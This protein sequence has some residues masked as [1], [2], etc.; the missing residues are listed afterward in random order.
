MNH[1]KTSPTT[2]KITRRLDRKDRK[3]RKRPSWDGWAAEEFNPLLTQHAGDRQ[4]QRNIPARALAAALRFGRFSYKQGALCCFFGRRAVEDARAVTG[5]D[6][7][8][9]EGIH[10][11][12]SA[13]GSSLMTVYRNKNPKRPFERSRTT[14]ERVRERGRRERL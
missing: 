12:Y 10:I 4:A 14:E 8:R 2:I 5:M 11:L 7:S 3:D 1:A 6:L 13:D 9:Y